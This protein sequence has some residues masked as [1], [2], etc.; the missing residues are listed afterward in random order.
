MMGTIANDSQQQE[1]MRRVMNQTFL[2]KVFILTI[3]GA[4]A[5]PSV[6]QAETKADLNAIKT[7]L[8]GRTT[9]LKVQAATLV[10]EADAYYT[11]AKTANFDYAAL[12]KS[13]KDAVAKSIVAAK[14][15]WVLASPMYE[16]MEGI[17]AGVPTLSEY[18]VILDAGASVEED[19]EGAVPF[20]LEL[21]DGRVLKQPGNLYGVLERTLWG[22]RADYTG[23]KEADL[24]ANGKIEFGESLP[25]A[26]VL[27]AG[28]DLFKKYVDDLDTSAQGW[29]PT[30]SD[31]FTALVVMVPTMS[32][33]FES[34]KSSRFVSGE[35][36]EQQDFNVISRLSDIEDILSGLQVVYDGVRPLVAGYDADQDKQI[37][38]ALKDLKKYVGDLRQEEKDGKVFTPEEADIFGSE[39]QDRATAI[40]GQ[41]SQVAAAL[42]IPLAE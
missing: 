5:V 12:W 3:A 32:E 37:D 27:K 6:A 31:A 18:D 42:N 14:E 16:Q 1:V 38:T 23:L 17:V 36:S 28:A 7:Y 11:L 39:A 4:L 25:E 22:T 33:Y 30:E 21:P 10:T 29:T 24:N 41:I 2:K 13:Q 26:N 8:L 9:E 34:W 20:D 40:V 19:P 35:K 15:T